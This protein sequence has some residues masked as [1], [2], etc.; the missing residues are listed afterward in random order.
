LLI[1]IAF[2]TVY[3]SSLLRSSAQAAQAHTLSPSAESVQRANQ[4]GHSA[5]PL[6][7]PLALNGQRPPAHRRRVGNLDSGSIRRRD[8]RLPPPQW[9]GNRQT[10]WS[11]TD[12]G[13]K[14]PFLHQNGQP[15]PAKGGGT[16]V[17]GSGMG[18]KVVNTATRQQRS[19]PMQNPGAAPSLVSFCQRS[20][21]S[22]Q[23]DCQRRHA[24]LA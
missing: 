8:L 16:L 1:R 24:A 23:A 13:A 17:V 20:G 11:L 2:Y 4:R 15:A 12:S 22:P 14:T 21:T 19:R 5:R 7:T 18:E 3:C 10:P 9:R 6:W